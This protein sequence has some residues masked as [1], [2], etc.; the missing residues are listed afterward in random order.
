M[1]RALSIVFMAFLVYTV[2]SCKARED[3]QYVKNIEDVAI[4]ESIKANTSTIQPGDQL[5]I[6]VLAK[7]NEV[8][9]PFNQNYYSTDMSQFSSVPSRNASIEPVYNVDSKGNIDFPILGTIIL[10]TKTLISLK[11]ILRK[12]L[13]NILK[14]QVLI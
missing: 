14:I 3:I 5:A 10:Q 13:Q 1:R 8:A 2:F 11:R 4:K 7:D 6:T 12:D 9:K